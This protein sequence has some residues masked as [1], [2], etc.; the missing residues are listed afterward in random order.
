[1]NWKEWGLLD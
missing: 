1:V